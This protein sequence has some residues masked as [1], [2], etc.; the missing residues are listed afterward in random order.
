MIE[1]RYST[2]SERMNEMA[3]MSGS[4]RDYESLRKNI[5]KFLESDNESIL[6]D[7]DKDADSKGWNYVLEILEIN[8]TGESV[9]VAVIENKIL[10][11]KGSK[12]KLEIFAAWMEFDEE[13]ASG[14][15]AH[16]EYF[17]G[18]EYIDSESIPLVIGIK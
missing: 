9:K 3:D 6:I 7:V 16:Y 4:W 18:N 5:L 8:Q 2:K 11:I 15:H 14:Y 12:E 1:I 13:N 17:E 10:K